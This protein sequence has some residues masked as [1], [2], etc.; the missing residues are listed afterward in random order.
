MK[1]S[2]LGALILA[3]SAH[4]QA[5]TLA[6]CA[7]IADNEDR[8]ACYDGLATADTT[9]KADPSLS[10]ST[11]E[12]IA[13]VDEPELL[14]SKRLKIEESSVNNPWVIIFGVSNHRISALLFVDHVN[15]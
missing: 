10:E 15:L 5:E 9:P 4:L 8:L 11:V 13:K 6:D 14:V 7:G 1:H 12:A 2:I 3:L